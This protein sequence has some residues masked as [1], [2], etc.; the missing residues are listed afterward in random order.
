MFQ[1]N[2]QITSNQPYISKERKRTKFLV[3]IVGTS[4]LMDKD[5]GMEEI[6]NLSLLNFVKNLY[7]QIGE[8]EQIEFFLNNRK[9]IKLNNKKNVCR[10]YKEKMQN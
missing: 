2:L 9:S 8:K 7:N 3:L 1:T 5:I 10:N 6:S 4:K